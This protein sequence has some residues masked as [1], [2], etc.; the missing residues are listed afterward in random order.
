MGRYLKMRTLGPFTPFMCEHPRRLDAH[1]LNSIAIC[2]F[3]RRR[4]RRLENRIVSR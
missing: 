2:G 1:F 4:R 3:R